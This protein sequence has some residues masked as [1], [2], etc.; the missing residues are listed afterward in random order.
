MPPKFDDE[1]IMQLIEMVNARKPPAKF[2]F[3]KEINL[4]HLVVAI[5][6]IIGGFSAYLTF[7]DHNLATDVRIKVV[8]EGQQKMERAITGINDNQ[9]QISKSLDKL[10]WIANDLR[11]ENK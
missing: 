8:E 10:T 6:F 9:S 11:K 7:H 5:T 2:S 3:S 4:G 1:H